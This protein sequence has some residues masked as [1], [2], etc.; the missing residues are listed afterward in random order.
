MLIE[1]LSTTLER[2]GRQD[3]AANLEMQLE[4][5]IHPSIWMQGDCKALP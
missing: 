4:T 1:T 2:L 5:A 3:V